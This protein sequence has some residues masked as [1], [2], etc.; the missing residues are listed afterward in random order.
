MFADVIRT[1]SIIDIRR[2]RKLPCAGRVL[3]SEGDQVNAGDIIA[4]ASL[5]SR[6]ILL[7]I[8]TGL[9]VSPDEV[10]AYLVRSIGDCLEQGDII[11]QFDGTL[12]RLVRTPADGRLVDVINGQA[13]VAAGELPLQVKAGMTGNV[14]QVIPEFG[15]M[16]QT[17]GSLLQG[18]W[19]NGGIAMGALHWLESSPDEPI[20]LS[21]LEGFE[22]GQMLACGLCF[23]A[24]L[25][26]FAHEGGAKGF[27]VNA[28]APEL[29]PTVMVLPLPVV[30]L[31]GFG[32]LPTDP[33]I[34][35]LLRTNEGKSACMNASRVDLFSAQRPEVII[36]LNER[37]TGEGLGFQVEVA[38]GCRVRILSGGKIGRSG[39]VVECPESP[40]RYESGL[41]YPSALIQLGEGE[42]ESVP[43][44]NL[45]VLE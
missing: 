10:K 19:G 7:D 14:A 40:V 12:S 32:A 29:I 4:E 9:G 6:M 5:P 20:S 42:T 26:E 21:A 45:V 28:L 38:E 39:V 17:R 34:R 30:V 33:V 43:L 35:D 1:A 16:L 24:A 31:A 18:V 41:E 2:T 25:L 44:K 37:M 11:A 3:V 23:Q 15:A 27:I 22:S 8:A 36:P 13:V